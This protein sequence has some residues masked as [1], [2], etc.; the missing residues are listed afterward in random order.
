VLR[1]SFIH[2][3][4]VGQNTE[5]WLW[6]QGLRSWDDCVTRQA[7]VTCGYP[8]ASSLRFQ[9]KESETRLRNGD[10]AFFDRLLPK[11]DSWRMYAD[12]RTRAAF[13]DVEMTG[14]MGQGE[15]TVIG[16]SNGRRT[17]VFVKGRNLAEFKDE[18]RDYALLVTYNGKLSDV[19][20][21]NK[22]F[23]NIFTHMGH[24]DLQY[25]LQRL[26]YLGGLKA[27]QEQLGFRRDEALRC[28]DGKCAVWLWEEHEKG[29]KRALETL[30]RYNLEDVVVLQSLAD[31]VYNESIS[32]LPVPV[33][34]LRPCKQ[35]VVDIPYD[36]DLARRLAKKRGLALR[37]ETPE[38]TIDFF[39]PARR[40]DSRSHFAG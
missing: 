2:M 6:K 29:N 8:L 16:L 9:A 40:R 26:G 11:S 36:V 34:K 13:V 23:G 15:I 24:L 7:T 10:A 19:P 1:N 17:K 35:P 14:P 30:I 3:D 28:L 33:W 27:I 12:F 32:L 18:I 4:G 39:P 31:T 21:M 22:T 38:A 37:E 25:S 20:A 5:R